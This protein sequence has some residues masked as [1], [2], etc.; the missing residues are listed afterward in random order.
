MAEARRVWTAGVGAGAEVETTGY[1]LK[2]G[3]LGGTPPALNFLNG[4]KTN[5]TAFGSS[6]ERECDEFLH[7]KADSRGNEAASLSTAYDFWGI[8]RDPKVNGGSA[9]G[10]GKVWLP[11]R[12]LKSLGG[13]NGNSNGG[14]R[15]KR[16]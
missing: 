13:I 14:Q 16:T 11:S 12:R 2:V 6:I 15:R 10:G 7:G 1:Y 5:T 4:L 8:R 9:K 3:G